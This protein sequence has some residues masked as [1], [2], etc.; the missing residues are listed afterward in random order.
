MTI[1]MRNCLKRL[2]G[3]FNGMKHIEPCD[4]E[5]AQ[6]HKTISGLNITR[7][8][9][10]AWSVSDFKR[11]RPPTEEQLRGMLTYCK[12][13][14]DMSNILEMRFSK[15]DIDEF[16]TAINDYVFLC[17]IRDEGGHAS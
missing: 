9:L 16:E 8:D 1:E 13:W 10:Q 5:H 14:D 15:S 2:Y 7:D 4:D 3:M 6:F 17:A 12:K 11:R